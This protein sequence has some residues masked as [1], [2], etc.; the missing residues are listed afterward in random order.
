M[1]FDSEGNFTRIHSWEEDRVNEIDIVSDRHDEED[2][3]FANGLNL[4]FLRDGRVPLSGS[5]N[6][7]NFQIKNVADGTVASDA[8]NKRQFDTALHKTGDETASGIKQFDGGIVANES[9]IT[10]QSE[11]IYDSETIQTPSIEFKTGEGETTLFT[12]NASQS[13]GNAMQA[14]GVVY[15]PETNE[16]K[17][18]ALIL[19]Y[20]EETGVYARTITPALNSNGQDIVTTNWINSFIKEKG[21]PNYEGAISIGSGYTTPSNGLL[22][23]RASGNDRTSWVDIG[24]VRVF[25]SSWGASYGSPDNASFSVGKNKII[26]FSGLVSATFYPIGE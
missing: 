10:I 5:L 3:N 2:D 11:S 1:P 21:T 15:N 26:T 19:G 13:A 6:M 24:S 23:V 7:N 14:V 8:V 20:S 16:R 22:I 9:T 17:G 12:L 18:E 4:A 25:D